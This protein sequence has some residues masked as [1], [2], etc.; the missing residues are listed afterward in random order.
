MAK[1]LKDVLKGKNA[2][3]KK[4]NDLGGYKPKAGDEAEFAKQHEIEKHEDRVGN[5]DSAYMAT[6]IKPVLLKPE[7]KRHKDAGGVYESKKAEDVS[8]NRT[9]AGTKCPIH[10]MADCSSVKTIKEM[11]PQK[12]GD[13]VKSASADVGHKK[14]D[15]AY[16][17]MSGDDKQADKLTNKA[18]QRLGNIYTA[19]NKI[20]RE[21]VEEIEELSTDTYH[22]AANVAAKRAMG[23][24]MGRSGPIFKKYAAK[25][26]KF[27]DKGMSQEKQEK[28]VKEDILPGTF[29]EPSETAKAKAKQ[30]QQ[31][32]ADK[33]IVSRAKM[34][35]TSEESYT[36][37]L[38]NIVKEANAVE[39]LLQSEDA[40]V[41]I[42]NSVAHVRDRK[43]NVVAKYSHETHGANWKNKAHAHAIRLRESDTPITLPGMNQDNALGQTL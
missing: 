30:V 19:V 2:S 27:R 39:P 26:N 6:N 40:T 18:R 42:R 31:K 23:D 10:E 38:R 24:A 37:N 1:Y 22:R 20:T 41:S 36:R 28:A 5:G 13:Y 35:I 9:K 8:C 11:T 16:A 34:G 14:A 4:V 33:A 32:D 12:Y 7:E 15:A 3:T 29:V 25:A 17:R 21:E 43:G